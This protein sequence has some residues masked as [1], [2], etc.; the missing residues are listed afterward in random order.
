M[1]WVVI[2]FSMGSSQSRDWTW[3]SHIADTFFTIWATKEA[4]PIITQ[5]MAK[6][7]N[8]LW[9][10][11]SSFWFELENI[12]AY[13]C[14]YVCVYFTKRLFYLHVALLIYII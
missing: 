8:L 7:F 4:H 1:E 13:L 14:V 2:A 6:K 12:L 11:S 5:A 9:F 10:K 3:V